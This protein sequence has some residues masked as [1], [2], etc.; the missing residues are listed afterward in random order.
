MNRAHEKIVLPAGCGSSDRLLIHVHRATSGGRILEKAP[1]VILAHGLEGSEES[2][3][4]VRFAEKLLRE[5]FHA[6]RMN[7]RGCGEGEKLATRLYDAGLSI[8]LHSVLEYVQKNISSKTALAGFSLSANLVLKYMGE[9]RAERQRQSFARGGRGRIAGRHAYPDVFIAVSPPLDLVASSFHLDA[10]SSFI[11]RK[12]FL[13]DMRA[14]V[15]KQNKFSNIPMAREK[16]KTVK[17]WVDF[18]HLFM[19]PTAGFPGAQEYYETSSS[20]RYISGIDRPGFVLHA[21]D[22]PIINRKTWETIRWKNRPWITTEL[23]RHGGH[24]GWLAERGSPLF[25]DRRWMDYRLLS[26]LHEWKKS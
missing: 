6:I 12:H 1:A 26:F 22:D 3:Y 18:D 23:T 9:D 16:L 13:S 19:A 24:M 5:G 11:Y 7:L 14:R 25:P 2:L 8:D 4:M 20:A 15:L 10:P 17:R 21:S